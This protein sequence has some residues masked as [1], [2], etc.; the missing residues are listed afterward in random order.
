MMKPAAAM[1]LSIPLFIALAC[2]KL[3]VWKLLPDGR[4]KTALFRFRGEY[5]PKPPAGGPQ[6]LLDDPTLVRRSPHKD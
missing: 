3:I 6:Y 2:A 1:V 4:L 5:D